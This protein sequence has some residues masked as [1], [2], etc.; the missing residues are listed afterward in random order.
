MDWPIV[1]VVCAFGAMVGS[2]LNV[3]IYRLPRGESIVWP[4][5]RCPSCQAPIPA[6]DNIPILSFLVLLG[7]CRR[8]RAP[9]RWRYPL[10][11][12]LN[13]FGY[14]LLF[15]SYG[16]TW[17]TAAYALLFSSLLVV[18]FIDLDHQIIPDLI[19]LPGIIIGL[20]AAA[21][22]LPPGV[23]GFWGGLIGLL[24]GGGF[25]YVVAVMSRGG[26]GGGDI[27]LIAM[28]GAFLGW[29]LVLLTIFLASLTGAVVGLG[30]MAFKGMGR[31]TPIP[32]G[33]F[34]AL[35]AI[36]AIFWGTAILEW[37]LT[38]GE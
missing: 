26:M 9:I 14:L 35:G 12:A 31:K 13:G 23:P 37:Y 17:T 25:F 22:V 16:L 19:T 36:M 28:I 11:E 33:P 27:K 7:R 1:A 32:F 5:S 18:T 3:C 6:Y 30:L 34:L 4:G 2:F 21:F 24:V 29:H 10:V 15:W 8:C 20:V 38:L